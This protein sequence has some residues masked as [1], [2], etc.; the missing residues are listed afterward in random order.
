MAHPSDSSV[1]VEAQAII[2]EKISTRLEVA[3]APATVTFATGATVQVNGAAPD[4]SVLVEIFARQGR[5]KPGQQKKVALGAFKLITLRQSRPNARLILAFA[6]AEA[7]A[8]VLGDG[9][10]AQALTVW[11]VEVLV[12]DLD[13]EQRDKIRAAQILQDMRNSSPIT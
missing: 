1:Q 5:L 13:D 12:V 3:L 11:G 7:A 6:D 8:H 9:W 2:R 4:E 10:L